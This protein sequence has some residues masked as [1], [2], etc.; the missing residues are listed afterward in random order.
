MNR[1]KFILTGASVCAFGIAGCIDQE[2][3]NDENDRNSVEDI[4]VSVER[5]IVSDASEIEVKTN[6]PVESVILISNDESVE[7]IGYEEGTRW[8]IDEDMLS[9]SHGEYEVRY[10]LNG[11]W[12]DTSVQIVLPSDGEHIEVKV[13]ETEVNRPRRFTV[14]TTEPVDD[15]WVTVQGD[16]D[17]KVTLQSN[18]ERLEWEIPPGTG[19]HP[20]GIYVINYE[21]DGVQFEH[22]EFVTVGDSEDRHQEQNGE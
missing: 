6:N 10:K 3:N 1:R 22:D 15:M 18:E 4:D 9:I 17:Y 14:T 13:D 7:L 5:E 12:Y 2:E 8:L 20:S 11:E 21:V 16:E 19:P